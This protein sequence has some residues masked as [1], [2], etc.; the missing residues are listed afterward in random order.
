M[1]T[2]QVEVDERTISVQ[3]ASYRKGYVFVTFG[4]LIV[5]AYRSLVFNQNTFD[6]LGLVMLGGLVTTLYQAQN[7]I[8]NRGYVRLAIVTFTVALVVAFLMA[9]MKK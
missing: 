3:N 9:T 1:S 5:A 2:K 4:I 8:L 6:L 7:K